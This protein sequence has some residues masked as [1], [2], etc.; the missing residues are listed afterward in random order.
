MWSRRTEPEGQYRAEVLPAYH[1][2]FARVSDLSR[3]HLSVRWYA[4]LKIASLY[5]CKRDYFA[6]REH[7]GC[8]DRLHT[9]H[10]R[11]LR[12][13]ANWQ[14]LRNGAGSRGHYCEQST[15]INLSHFP[16]SL[17][18]SP[19]IFV[20]RMPPFLKRQMACGH[21]MECF[22]NLTFHRAQQNRRMQQQRST[23]THTHI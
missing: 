20:A 14:V 21:H 12:V 1:P 10:G 7:L 16:I 8:K 13:R 17:P 22:F 6:T 19:F 3:V 18:L 23:S 15:F 9:Q 4:V 11:K 2:I 5:L